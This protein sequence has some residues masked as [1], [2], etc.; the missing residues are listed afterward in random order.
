MAAGHGRRVLCP[1]RVRR[2]PIPGDHPV[3]PAVAGE[4]LFRGDL[5]GKNEMDGFYSYDTDNM[6]LLGI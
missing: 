3:E 5:Q 6:T 1:L 4:G 2:H